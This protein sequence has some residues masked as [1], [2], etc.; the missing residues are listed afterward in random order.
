LTAAT[1]YAH[2]LPGHGQIASQDIDR[3]LQASTG[4]PLAHKS[5]LQ[6]LTIRCADNPDHGQ[7]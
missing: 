4:R 3:A 5:G 7:G 6:L 1:T 2:G